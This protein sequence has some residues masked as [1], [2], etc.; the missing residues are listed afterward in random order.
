M[1]CIFVYIPTNVVFGNRWQCHAKVSSHRESC[2]INDFPLTFQA[3][4]TWSRVAG[5]ISLSDYYTSNYKCCRD[6]WQLSQWQ[7]SCNLDWEEL[8][9]LLNSMHG[10]RHSEKDPDRMYISQECR[11]TISSTSKSTAAV[12]FSPRRV[13]RDSNITLPS[14]ECIYVSKAPDSVTSRHLRW[15]RSV[16]LSEIS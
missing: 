2:C 11:G 6:M 9:W 12:T 15:Q 10:E 8:I 5:H 7:R 16:L 3:W 1:G 14:R 4:R 13:L